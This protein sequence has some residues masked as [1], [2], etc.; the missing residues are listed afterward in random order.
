MRK[1]VKIRVLPVI[2]T[3]VLLCVAG[4]LMPS[5][6]PRRQF[7]VAVSIWPGVERLLEAR[8]SWEEGNLMELS[9]S[10]AVTGAFHK[11]VA[12]AAVVSLDELLRLEAGDAQPQAVIVLGVSAGSDVL[13]ARP[14]IAS[15][16]ELRG[17]R[18]GV[19]LRSAGEYLLMRVLR[20]HGMVLQD[21]EVEPL[22]LAETETA[23]LENDLDAVVTTDPWRARLHDAG[24]QTLADSGAM[25][26]EM[27][28]VLVVRRDAPENHDARLRQLLAASLA[29][30][31]H[32]NETDGNAEMGALLRRE[33]LNLR[34]WQ[35]AIR[36]VRLPGVSENHRLM[37][38]DG[39]LAEVLKEMS[40]RMQAAG[41]LPRAVETRRLL[42]G[43]FLP[44][45]P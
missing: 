34:Q 16:A 33:E 7:T 31:G 36:L 28:R 29:H 4:L 6:L 12:D 45:I 24:A 42:N 19:E 5:T 32:Q 44:P 38:A 41:M 3:G 14:G 35:Q 21:V 9:W 2:V 8:G 20:M 27:S 43:D 17:K 39:P 1:T 18:V 22:N 40:V 23:Y 30:P 25:G 15:V 37:E 13:M 10:G 11:R 26:L